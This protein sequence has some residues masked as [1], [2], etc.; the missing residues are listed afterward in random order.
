MKILAKA[1]YPT[2]PDRS[3]RSHRAAHHRLRRARRSPG[4]PAIPSS[5]PPP[6]TPARPW[7]WW[8][9]SAGTATSPSPTPSA[10]RRSETAWWRR[11]RRSAHRRQGRPP[12][13]HP[14][15]Y[16]NLEATLCERNPSYFPVNQYENP[17][18]PD[19]HY[20][21]L[22][23]E[24]WKQTKGKVTHFIGRIHRRHRQRHRQI[25]QGGVQ[26]QGQSLDA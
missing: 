11:R 16:V 17:D 23:P 19:A 24:I 5:R 14:E 12:A 10:R 1:E 18:N 15:H 2:P 3:S 22:G 4:N 13:D 26:G 25:P 7:P 6:A 20:Q 21:T 9:P 8:P